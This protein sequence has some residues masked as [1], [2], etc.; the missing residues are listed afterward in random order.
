MELDGQINKVEMY[1]FEPGNNGMIA[2]EDIDIG[3]LIC[4][5]PDDFFI[6]SILAEEQS[7]IV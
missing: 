1:E 6:S 4:Y 7:Q 3:D 2:T 5:V